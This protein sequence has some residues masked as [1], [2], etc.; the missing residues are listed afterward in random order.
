MSLN[1]DLTHATKEDLE[2]LKSSVMKRLFE[3]AQSPALRDAEGYDRHGSGH[4]RSGTGSTL[5]EREI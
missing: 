2:Q 4:S 5:Q 1:I 3:K